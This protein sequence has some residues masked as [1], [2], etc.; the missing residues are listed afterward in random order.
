MRSGG[1]FDVLEKFFFA[2]LHDFAPAGWQRSG[3]IRSLMHAGVRDPKIWEKTPE[4][5][6]K[7]DEWVATP[8]KD[9]DRAQGC[10]R[11]SDYSSVNDPFSYCDM[12]RSSVMRQTDLLDVTFVL[13]AR[14]NQC[15][16][17]CI[18][19]L[20]RKVYWEAFEHLTTLN[21]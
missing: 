7:T 13:C 16:C 17:P 8:L 3:I 9:L 11:C 1:Q 2:P 6:C 14:S 18:H 21:S 10:D 20:Y 15:C 12:V 5:E 4:D 19:A